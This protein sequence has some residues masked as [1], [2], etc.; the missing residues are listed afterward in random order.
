[1]LTDLP[2]LVVLIWVTVVYA[3]YVAFASAR[4]KAA[5]K[6]RKPKPPPGVN[7]YL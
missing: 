4:P 5:P 6:K 3:A 7:R 2:T 1:V